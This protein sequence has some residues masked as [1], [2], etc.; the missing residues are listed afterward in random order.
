MLELLEEAE[1]PLDCS[2]TCKG[3]CISRVELM[4]GEIEGWKSP[5]SGDE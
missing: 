4:E 3:I 1:P 5:F 2:V